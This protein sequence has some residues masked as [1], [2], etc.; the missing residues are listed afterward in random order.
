MVP[1]V[2]IPVIKFQPNTE[3]NDHKPVNTII[4]ITALLEVSFRP[5]PEKFDCHPQIEL[6]NMLKTISSLI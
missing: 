2:S 1:H 6:I 4:V 3:K 5:E